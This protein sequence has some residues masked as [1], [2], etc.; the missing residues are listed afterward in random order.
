MITFHLTV[1]LLA[2][3]LGTANLILSQGDR[4]ASSHGLGV[5]GADGRRNAPRPWRSASSM[6][7]A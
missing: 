4:A 5:D 7:G 1:A 6:M 2:F 3:A